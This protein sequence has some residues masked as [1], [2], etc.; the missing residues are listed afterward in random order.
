[1][2]EKDKK[3]YK[4]K[5][6]K[7][8][9][10]SIDIGI[11]DLVHKINENKDYYTTSSCS[12]RIAL[13]LPEKKKNKTRWLFVSH[14]LVDYKDIVSRLKDIPKGI[15]FFKQESFILHVV[16]RNIEAAEKILKISRK[17]G[18]KRAGI[19]SLSKK[20]NIEI[21]YHA[22]FE[23]IIAEDKKIIVDENYVKKIVKIANENMKKNK[24]KIEEFKSSFSTF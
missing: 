18:L 4:E 17:L 22:G 24:K 5:K 12:G 14:G 10:G 11:S 9:K 21:L 19:Q 3:R 1:M 2:F 6:D 13:I 23:T 20:I 8:K 7:S 15:L 16:A